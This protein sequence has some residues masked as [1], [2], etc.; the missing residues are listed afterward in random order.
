MLEAFR[1]GKRE[2]LSAVYRHYWPQVVE[3]AAHG[4]TFEGKEGAF[5]FTGFRSSADLFDVATD[6]FVSLFEER[7]RHAYS[8][9]S[10]YGSYVAV[11]TRNHIL[12]RL[13]KS[14][15]EARLVVQATDTEWGRTAPS[16]EDLASG[17]QMQRIVAA[18]LAEQNEGVRA[19]AR[20]RFA[21]DLSQEETAAAL[22]I[23]RKQVRRLEEKLRTRLRSHLQRS[24]GFA[25]PA[26][27]SNFLSL[28]W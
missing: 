24:M 28:F 5:R 1:K 8:G 17:R 9:A 27:V 26:F 6:V 11:A 3:L 7:S 18:F 10:P 23:S 12:T 22:K 19:V 20:C 21:E 4:F 16:P 25:V 15:S 13:R 14:R 2:A